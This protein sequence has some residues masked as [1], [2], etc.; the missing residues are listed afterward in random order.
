MQ[1]ERDGLQRR[2]TVLQDDLERCEG[3][4]ETLRKEVDEKTSSLDETERLV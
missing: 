3:Q 2:L 4:V 1:E